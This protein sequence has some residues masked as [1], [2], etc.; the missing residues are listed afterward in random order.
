MSDTKRQSK[1]ACALQMYKR[2]WGWSQFRVT[3]LK[4]DL[5]Y[6][7]F[8]ILVGCVS[9]PLEAIIRAHL[10]QSFLFLLEQHLW[11][12]AGLFCNFFILSIQK[13]AVLFRRLPSPRILNYDHVS[14]VFRLSVIDHAVRVTPSWEWL[15]QWEMKSVFG[16]WHVC[17]N[18]VQETSRN[19]FSVFWEEATNCKNSSQY[20]YLTYIFIKVGHKIVKNTLVMFP[21][22]F[23]NLGTLHSN[24]CLEIPKCTKMNKSACFMV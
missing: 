22:V 3:F 12:V 17:S 20:P 8:T 6:L 15:L 21:C 10:L 5:T 7:D 4:M 9:L 23:V 2:G 11:S 13:R 14:E 19:R 18:T 1:I 24:L 16:Y